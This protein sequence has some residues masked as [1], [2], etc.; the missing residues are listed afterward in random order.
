VQLASQ[1]LFGRADLRELDEATLAAALR[2]AAVDG[3]VAEVRSGEPSTIVDLLVATGLSESRGAARRAVNE[4]GA[5][6]NNERI[7]DLEWSPADA[8]YLHGRWLVLRR[9]KRNFAGVVRAGA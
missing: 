7:S 9:G 5:S 8:D 2:E 6:V 1:A 3:A 4:G